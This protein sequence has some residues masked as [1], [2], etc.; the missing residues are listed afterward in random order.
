[1]ACEIEGFKN[2]YFI[3]GPFVYTTKVFN[4]LMNKFGINPGCRAQ[5]NLCLI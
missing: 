1:M 4:L 5:K 2:K 3:T